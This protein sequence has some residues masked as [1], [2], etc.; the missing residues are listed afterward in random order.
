MLPSGSVLGW[1]LIGRISELNQIAR[2]RLDGASGIVVLGPAG[3][4]KSRLAREALAE[5]EQ[6][7]ASTTWVQATRSG[8]SVP[9]GAFAGVVPSEA[10]SDDLLQ[11]MR[12][13]VK[14]LGD[15]AG[16]RTL[17]LG[18][19]DAQLL[20]PTSAALVLQLAISSTAFVVATIRAGERCPDA[21]TTLWKDAGAQ[22]LELG[23]LA[24]EESG[25]LA[26]AIVGGPIEQ[27]ARR[28]ICDT[29]R[30]NALYV[31]ELVLGA[32]AGGALKEVNG[33]WRL[34]VRP[35]VS[36]SIAELITARM[37]GLSGP[38]RETLELL[39]L[40]EPLPLSEMIALS[41]TEQLTSTEARGLIDVDGS[42]H[43]HVKLAHPLYGEAIRAT[44]PTLRARQ[45]RLR[46]AAVL[47]SRAEPQPQDELRIA[48]WLL[49][50]GESIP[51]PLLVQAAK[52]ANLAGDP[53][54][55]AELAARAMD[56]GA[57]IQA[58][59]LLARAHTIQNQHEQAETVLSAAEAKID[60]Q[61]TALDYLEQQTEVLY[62]GLKRPEELR[63][64]LARAETWWPESRWQDRLV[65]LRLRVAAA[66]GPGAA[67]VISAEILSSEDLDPEVRRQ[68]EP[69]HAASLFYSGRTREAYE[70][71]RRIRP[72]L[73]LRDLT[74]ELAFVLWS[75]IAIETGEG[76]REL[77]AWNMKALQEGV[78][79]GDRAASGRAALG[80]GGLRFSEGRYF[81]A[82]RWLAEAELQ[83]EHHDAIGLLAITNSLQVGVACFTGS[84]AE[85]QPALERC[86]AALG[87]KDPL[88]NQLPHL[89][90]AEA[91]AAN[92]D[93]D[94]ARA[95]RLLLGAA[96]ELS[97]MPVYA[98]RLTYEAI[99]AGGPARR[100]AGQLAHLQARCD[101]RLLA[102][103]T[104]HAVA[105]AADDGRAL[106]QTVD[107]ME[108]IGALRYATEAAAHAASAFARAGRQDSARRATAR[109]R[110][111]Q[112]RG[113]GGLPPPI[114]G[115]DTAAVS[116]TPRERQLV[117]LAT[118][119]LSNA[120][121]GDRLV[122]S[123]RT[124]ESHLYRAMQKL[125]VSDR[126]EL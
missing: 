41:G 57:G 60:T 45:V 6:A 94:P 36:A 120:Q 7:G 35:P 92:A 15:L 9:L 37:A 100:L 59:L 86:R 65:P 2:S 27:G 32:L 10:R 96:E 56:A 89:V 54:L 61:R 95:Q 121:I 49:D 55:G 33:H 90:R 4:G 74:D 42:R 12:L 80:L 109:S 69:L 8:A 99:R 48:R 44:L 91:W 126:H 21:I 125:G 51:T 102:A 112:A 93:G 122:L 97:A 73:P 79:L 68:T 88:P 25:T 58:A 70:L 107:E 117:E 34:P 105:L 77:E 22:R 75:T 52:A 1:P 46:L 113:Q 18:V 5:A 71:A 23:T 85:V 11:L 87:G 81:D 115:I 119:G 104:A 40:G 103:Y 28:W 17:V 72:L 29:S 26:E 110:Q 98:A 24:E 118:R 84:T 16:T 39:A 78:R 83:L 76:W 38:E 62:W 3:V 111:L 124:V 82:S 53:T 66:D 13:S 101:G 67:V 50:A 47:Q 63:E 114:E 123:V 64:L 19:D 31:R 116:L 20:D 106:L 30:G 108:E 14:A 43:G